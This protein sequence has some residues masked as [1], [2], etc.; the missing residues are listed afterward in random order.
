MGNSLDHSRLRLDTLHP[1]SITHDVLNDIHKLARRHAAAHDDGLVV[2]G[3]TKI[4]YGI[5]VEGNRRLDLEASNAQVLNGNW[6][7]HHHFTGDLRRQ[8]KT[9]ISTALRMERRGIGSG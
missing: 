4:V 3:E 9:G 6:L 5:D 8:V 2:E 7:Y 1:G